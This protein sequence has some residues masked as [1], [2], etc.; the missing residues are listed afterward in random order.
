[1]SKYNVSVSRCAYEIKTLPEHFTWWSL[2]WRHN[3]HDVVSNHQPY[4][5]FATVYAGADQGKH[6]SSASLA[7]VRGIHR[8]PVN[9]PHK[10]PV[11][12]KMFPFDDV[13]MIDVNLHGLFVIFFIY[14]P[15]PTASDQCYEVQYRTFASLSATE[16]TPSVYCWRSL[17]LINVFRTQR[18]MLIVFVLHV[19][20]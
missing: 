3:L 4:D 15:V 1:M 6:Q 18:V 8:W 7:I 13:I 12:R 19:D 9:S 20:G 11:T 2:Q 10:G 17:T 5:C 16:S 14:S